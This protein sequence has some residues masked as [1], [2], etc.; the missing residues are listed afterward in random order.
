MTGS[1]KPV[2]RMI[3]STIT[4]PARV[5][6]YSLG[7]ADTNTV[8]GVRVSHS[9]KRRGRLSRA[10]GKRKPKSTKVSLRE[11]SPFHM[12]PIWG[13][14]WCDSSTKRRKSLGK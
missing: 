14:V 13:T 12:E 9:S 11:R 6:S 3:C 2:G 1:S 8:C 5:S 7:V 4:P 10:D